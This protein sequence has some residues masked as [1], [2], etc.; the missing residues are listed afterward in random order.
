MHEGDA[1]F[2]AGQPFFTGRT[3]MRQ[4][5]RPE[6]AVPEYAVPEYVFCFDHFVLFYDVLYSTFM[7][8]LFWSTLLVD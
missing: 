1:L 7:R 8:H 4:I 2:L 6:Y 5:L 3:P